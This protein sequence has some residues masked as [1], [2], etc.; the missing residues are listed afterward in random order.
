[1]IKTST[2]EKATFQF[3]ILSDDQIE[4]IKW[5]AFDV[6]RTVGF[7]VL[8]K[9]GRK[10]LKQAGALVREDRVKVPEHIIRECLRLAPK[11]WTVFNRDGKRAMEVQGRKSY[12]GTSTA[13]PNNHDMLTGKI[14]PT[15]LADIAM[16]A[17]LADALDHIDFIM[18]FGSSQDVPG[19]ACDINE[20][21]AIVS[22]TTKPIVFIGYSGRGVELVYE[23]AA[24]VAGGLENL[25]E[26]PFVIAYPESIAPLVF[27]QE[28]VDRIFAAASLNMPQIPCADIQLGAT[29]PMTAAGATVQAL[30]E[31]LM[32]LVLAQ[33]KKPGCP[34]CL[35]TTVGVLDMSRGV[36]TFGAPTN[37]TVLCA[38]A[39]VAQS[40]GLPTWGT[41]GAT[42]AKV[43]DAQS[44]AETAFQILTQAMAGINLIHDVG[45]IDA[46]M[47]CSAQQMVFGNE[48][49]GMVKHFLKG[50]TVNRKTLAREVIEA[51]GPG[52]HFLE[53]Q[54][55]LD[56]FRN[57]LWFPKL[58]NRQ[59][60]SDWEKDGSKDLAA[61]ATEATIQILDNHVPQH[62]DDNIIGKLE[63]FGKRGEVELKNRQAAL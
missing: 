35:A 18:P 47:T 20:F 4:E 33:L 46:V 50:V 41:A 42:D 22:N 60:R 3:R 2:V 32:G 45:Y 56:H 63:I 9:E 11:G 21:P 36:T 5:A 10:L 25:Q 26:R 29:G 62:L 51:V 13:S 31:G 7:K 16:G 54:H 39:E 15:R 12:F 59:N 6:M 37:S 24:T 23:M 48:V 53:H 55:T 43:V 34:V 28:T 1:M 57:E 38:H 61:R 19:E 49:I 44:G 8:H 17:R 58:M 40:F 27:P 14:H 30:V 52:G